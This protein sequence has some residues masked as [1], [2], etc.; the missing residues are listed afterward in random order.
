[1]GKEQVARVRAGAEDAQCKVYL[2]GTEIICRGG[3]KRTFAAAAVKGLKLRGGWIEFDYGGEK[4]EIEIGEKAGAWVEAIRNPRTRMEKLG[5]TRGMKVCVLG[6]A[7]DDA[8]AELAEVL[9]AAPAR[10]AGKGIDVALL[11]ARD[12]EELERLG[13]LDA[14]LA[15][16]GA[17]WVLW[18]KGRKD[19]AHEDVVKA[20]KAAGLSQTKSIGFSEALSG[21]RLVRAAKQVKR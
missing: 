15:A 21:L 9:G 2:E 6:R 14:A 10:R 7:E 20:G 5:V 12:P 11:F 16:G 13:K 8:V 1:M 19:L 3:V 4:V 17:V 18:P